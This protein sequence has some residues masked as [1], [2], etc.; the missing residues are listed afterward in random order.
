M[1]K[2]QRPKQ[3]SAARV[4]AG[5]RTAAAR[6]RFDGKFVSKTFIQENIAPAAALRGLISYDEERQRDPQRSKLTATEMRAVKRFAEQHESDFKEIWELGGLQAPNE[7][8]D[9]TVFKELEQFEKHGGHLLLNGEESSIDE[10]KFQMLRVE[11]WLFSNTNAAGV[12]FKPFIYFKGKQEVRLPS[13]EELEEMEEMDE[14]ELAEYLDEEYGLKVWM[15]PKQRPGKTRK[16]NKAINDRIERKAKAVKKA[17]KDAKTKV[18]T[19][20][21]RS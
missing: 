2:Q 15:S 16:Q 9:T 14:T 17:L 11:Q 7:K 3:K 6:I 10:I 12:A 5:K 4:A 18:R 8:Q 13:I 1:A 19:K 21:R 20:R